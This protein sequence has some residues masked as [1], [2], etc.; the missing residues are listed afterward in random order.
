MMG[1]CGLFFFMVGY[2]RVRKDLVL[3]SGLG[4]REGG[5]R[6]EGAPNGGAGLGGLTEV[7]AHFFE[8]FREGVFA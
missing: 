6:R 5:G 4:W 8:G 7:E 1:T 3:V 2:A